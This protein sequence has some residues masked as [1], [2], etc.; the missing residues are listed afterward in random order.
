MKHFILLL[1]A[2]ALISSAFA[3][4]PQQFSYQGVARNAGLIV[5]TNVCVRFT[6]HDISPTGTNVYQETHVVTPNAFGVFS[7]TIG[8]GTVVS[9]SMTGINWANGAKYLQVEMD[10][11]GGSSYTDLGTTQFVSVPYAIHSNTADTANALKNVDYMYVQDVQNPGATE[12]LLGNVWN[13]RTFNTVQD[14]SGTAITFNH[15]SSTFT[16]NQ[17][18]AYHI[19]ASSTSRN[20]VL[21]H[22]IINASGTVLAQGMLPPNGGSSGFASNNDI[23]AV[24]NI[25]T[26]QTIELDVIGDIGPGCPGCTVANGL[27]ECPLTPTY[28]PPGVCTTYV[29]ASILIQKIK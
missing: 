21:L 7:T 8:S 5:T 18:G 28:F 26:P 22:A 9:G 1:C 29:F 13:K 27:G 25:T 11:S 24:I 2:T 3:Q 4:S 16:L 20:V 17:P 23:D 12:D 15:S 6:V 10:A 19:R 14:S